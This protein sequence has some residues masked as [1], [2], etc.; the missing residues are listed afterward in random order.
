[1]IQ[2]TEVLEFS[3]VR[4]ILRSYLHGPLVL[5]LLQELQSKTHP[6]EICEELASVGEAVTF[7]REN[8]PPALG[9]LEDPKPV[10]ERLRITGTF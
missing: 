7:L 4:E 3:G 2:S 8:T 5:E 9:L 10:L 6:E 1:M